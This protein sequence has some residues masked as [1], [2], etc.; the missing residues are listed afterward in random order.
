M[1]RSL[2]D[3]G[4]PPLP[5]LPRA[6]RP[7]T[8]P[9]H[10][11]TPPPAEPVPLASRTPSPRLPPRPASPRPAQ[12]PF[13]AP[14]WPVAPAAGAPRTE[15]G[16]L[17]RS[18]R[19]LSSG[20]W[21]PTM[22]HRQCPRLQGEGGPGSNLPPEGLPVQAD[23]AAPPACPRLPCRG[24]RCSGQGQGRRRRRGLPGY[25]WLPQAEPRLNRPGRSSGRNQ[26]ADHTP[27]TGGAAGSGLVGTCG[28]VS[29][30]SAQ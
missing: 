14:L 25:V 29:D 20:A 22:P 12:L 2:T 30:A 17:R 6:A 8:P 18:A 13:S 19:S 9:H 11:Q 4:G 23:A 28:C 10:G 26:K 7:P 27:G 21:G 3:G 15:A 5:H 24:L 1:G 16:Q